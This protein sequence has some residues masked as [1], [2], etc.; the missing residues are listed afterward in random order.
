MATIDNAYRISKAIEQMARNAQ[1]D[2]PDLQYGVVNTLSPL[3]VQLGEQG[4]TITEQFLIPSPWCYEKMLTLNIDGVSQS[5][6]LWRPLAEG[7]RVQLLRSANGQKWWITQRTDGATDYNDELTWDISTTPSV[8]G[9]NSVLGSRIV[10]MARTQIGVSEIGSSNNVKYNTWYYGRSVAGTQYPWCAV[11]VS[12]C[13]DQ[14]GLSNKI[15]PRTAAVATFESFYRSRGLLFAA[16]SRTP[17][18]G[19]FY[20]YSNSSHIGI[21]ESVTDANSWTGIEGN[22]SNQVRRRNITSNLVRYIMQP[23]YPSTATDY[24]VDILARVMYLEAGSDWIP[25]QV[26]EKVASVVVNRVNDSSYPNTVQG[27]L[28]QPGQFSTWDRINT[29]A[30]T[31]RCYAISRQI[32]EGGTVIPPNVVFFANFT[33]GSGTYYIYNNPYGNNLYFCYK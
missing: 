33:Q 16:G 11:F 10:Q 5:Q 4:E 26:L 20:S 24:D 8:S 31:E 15:V 21:V 12:W 9:S 30:P 25:N 29:I 23:A 19:D 2:I 7:D 18:P 17:R 6:A 32:L 1:E 28:S 3:S 22:T 27:V 14:A 13:A